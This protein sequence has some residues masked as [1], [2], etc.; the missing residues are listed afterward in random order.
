MD[1]MSRDDKINKIIS[2][3]RVLLIHLI[4]QAVEKRSTRSWE[5]SIEDALD[6]AKGQAILLAV[7]AVFAAAASVTATTARAGPAISTRTSSMRFWRI[8]TSSRRS[9]IATIDD[10]SAHVGPEVHGVDP[11]TR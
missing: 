3:M 5:D 9:R 4:K 8:P 2:Y 11:V 1:E 7:A 10:Q 6:A